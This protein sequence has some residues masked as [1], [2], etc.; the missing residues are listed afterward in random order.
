[1]FPSNV[2]NSAKRK[3]CLP[4]FSLLFWEFFS[5]AVNFQNLSDLCLGGQKFLRFHSVFKRFY[6]SKRLIITGLERQNL[7]KLPL[8]NNFYVSLWVSGKLEA[9]KSTYLV[10]MIPRL[11]CLFL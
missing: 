7:H 1:M 2:A 6:N 10:G 9:L 11:D 5:G 3:T 4:L 8:K